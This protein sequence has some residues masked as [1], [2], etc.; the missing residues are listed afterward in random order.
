MVLPRDAKSA[1]GYAHDWQLHGNLRY[2]RISG[3]AQ[4]LSD[5]EVVVAGGVDNA[6]GQFGGCCKAT[7]GIDRIIIDSG[8]SEA[9]LTM[10]LTGVGV[11]RR[12]NK[13][14]AAGGRTFGFTSTGQ[15]RY[16]AH[17]EMIDLTSG[18]VQQLPNVPF[19]S[20]GAKAVWLD[21]ERILVKGSR[22]A[23]GGRGFEPGED[24]ASYMPPSSG[25][26]AIYHVG[27]RRWSEAI[28]MPELE[29]AE[30]ISADANSAL[31]FSARGQVLKFDF[32]SSKIREV[33]QAQRR[34]TGD[35]SRLI[36]PGQLVFAGGLV[37]RDTVSVVDEECETQRG[38]NA[39]PE[40][41]VGFGPQAALAVVESISLTGGGPGKASTLSSAGPEG[42]VSTTI[43]ARWRTSDG[44]SRPTGARS[45]WRE[46]QAAIGRWPKAAPARTTGSNCRCP[47]PQTMPTDH[48]GCHW[49]LIHVDRARSCCSF[50]VATP[51]MFWKSG[52]STS[53]T[54]A[55][56]TS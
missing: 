34:R 16:S 38:G 11:A 28:A 6:D 30:L 2:R 29:H 7:A 8:A 36:A 40:R 54:G 53:A 50:S 12:G 15:M 22:G 21:E 32:A 19:A 27:Q 41:F 47:S 17:A 35:V 48:A 20:G 52:G 1:S 33:V 49:R 39:C 26:M 24:L 42:V 14:F 55:G 46:R 37:Q 13:V 44:C 43:G 9:S 5:R 56:S 51:T 3:I 45:S 31:L 25:A 18:A 4:A 23:D 10:R